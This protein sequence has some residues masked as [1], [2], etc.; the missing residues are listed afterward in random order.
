VEWLVLVQLVP[1]VLLVEQLAQEPVL[2]QA[3]L[4]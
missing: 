1:P 4:A 3:A 2:V